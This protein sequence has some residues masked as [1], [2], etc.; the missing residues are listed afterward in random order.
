[1][2]RDK[3]E[4]WNRALTGYLGVGKLANTTTATPEQEQCSLHYDATVRALLEEDY[5][6]WARLRTTLTAATNDRA[7]EWAYKYIMPGDVLAIRWINDAQT[8]RSL[9]ALGRSPDTPREIYTEYVYSDVQAAVME[10]T[11]LIDDESVWPQAFADAV[12]ATLAS[13]MAMALT[14]NSRLAQRAMQMAEQHLETAMERDEMNR[15]ATEVDLKSSW[16]DARVG[17]I[18][19]Y[20]PVLGDG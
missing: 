17:G 1:M 14:E 7:S 13:H 19:P 3:L 11:G 6:S 20:P 10:Y 2:A 9:I 15:D 12:S 16:I 4:I 5:W 8:A 18:T